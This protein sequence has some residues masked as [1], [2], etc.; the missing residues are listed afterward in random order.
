MTGEGGTCDRRAF[1][2]RSLG[3]VA[4]AAVPWAC[5]SLAVARVE[6]RDGVVRLH[7]DHPGLAR[8]FLEVRPAGYDTPV[9]VLALD[10]GWSAVSPICT[11]Q[12]CTVGVEGVRLVC[13][14]HGSTY[15][16]R[17]RLLVGPA[18]RDLRAYPVEVETDGTL[19]I[20]LGPS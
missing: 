8:G 14:C 4:A 17:G 16:R 12:G 18:E 2:G 19:A 13:P 6:P 20:T 15:D 7:P 5:A 9:Y 1:V 3:L 10:D 11:H